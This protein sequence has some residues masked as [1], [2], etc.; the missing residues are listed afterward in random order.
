M[1][2]RVVIGAVLLLVGAVWIAQGIGVR[3]GSPMT[4]E[5]VWAI[6]GVPLVVVGLALLRSA[7]AS[8]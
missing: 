6:I 4:G 5:A 2:I 3:H 7:R 1:W 8:K